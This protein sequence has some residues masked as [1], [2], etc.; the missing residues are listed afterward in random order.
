[1][2]RILPD[3]AR[4]FG[5]IVPQRQ[6]FMIK[7]QSD[8][9]KALKI[10]Q[11]IS[12]GVGTAAQLYNVGSDIYDRYIKETPEE[13]LRRRQEELG[14]AQA[15]Q[16][17]AR[18]VLGGGMVGDQYDPMLG[19]RVPDLSGF[20]QA[21]GE[22]AQDFADVAALGDDA[23]VLKYD[24]PVPDYTG[25]R[26]G[27]DV[28]GLPEPAPTLVPEL[29]YRRDVLG[30][31][32]EQIKAKPMPVEMQPDPVMVNFGNQLQKVV[33]AGEPGLAEHY[34]EKTVQA[35][36]DRGRPDLAGKF[37][38]ALE[39]LGGP[40]A[41]AFEFIEQRGQ[42]GLLD[43]PRTAAEFARGFEAGEDFAVADLNMAYRSL[44]NAG[45]QQEAEELVNLA[46]ATMDFGQFAKSGNEPRSLILARARQA[47]RQ[48]VDEGGVTGTQAVKLAT[49]AAK[50][51]RR[52][53]PSGGKTRR[54]K[55]SAMTGPMT[56]EEKANRSFVIVAART[57]VDAARK[58]LY[59]GKAKDSRI[60]QE[61]L[62]RRA[63]TI[64]EG[65]TPKQLRNLVLRSGGENILLGE[66]LP[67]VG[68]S[69]KT[70]TTA[71]TKR[72][73]L[74]EDIEEREDVVARIVGADPT[75][76]SQ[77]VIAKWLKENEPNAKLSLKQYTN[78]VAFKRSVK[79][80]N[81]KFTSSQLKRAGYNAAELKRAHNQIIKEVNSVKTEWARITQKKKQ[82][83][84]SGE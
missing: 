4:G 30:E 10:M 49:S 75:A 18:S 53:T 20:A 74:T 17:I 2:A 25:A 21:R 34:V 46:A 63:T 11:A 56:K 44:W 76:L 29:A 83:E 35:A 57:S 26:S 55:R 61:T 69:R 13:A 59:S 6:R 3:V 37:R 15:R 24:K 70:E 27:A 23:N 80:L 64:E 60:N 52:R 48:G 71:K 81:E 78:R 82:L 45:R 38:A 77:N 68:K 40:E 9:D 47:I 33:Q 7:K 79:Q 28:A 67:D 12:G 66:L 84:E 58:I 73:K 42:R 32:P 19:S 65:L 16:N 5:P 1:M 50:R 41:S 72:E 54:G 51:R 14:D 39:K 43:R 62:N 31:T 22:F 36:L 8:E